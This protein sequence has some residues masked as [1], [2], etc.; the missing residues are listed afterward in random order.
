[1]M[2]RR[3]TLRLLLFAAATLCC[4]SWSAAYDSVLVMP[5]VDTTDPMVRRVVAA[6]R[7]TIQRWR[8]PPDAD[9]DPDRRGAPGNVAGI[10]RNWCSPTPAVV[11]HFPATIMSV[12]P[13][14]EMHYVARVIISSTDHAGSVIPFAIIRAAFDVRDS[15]PVARVPLDEAT[16]EWETARVGRITYVFPP[17]ITFRKRRAERANAFLLRTAEALGVQP[18]NGV[19][20]VITRDR[21]ELCSILGVEYLAVPPSAITYPVQRTV[22]VGTHEEAYLHELVHIVLADYPAGHEVIREGIAT[23]YGGSLGVDLAD[24][25]TT[26]ARKT[27]PLEVPTLTQL[28]TEGER[29]QDD[30]YIMGAV[31]CDAIRR[32]HGVNTLID[33]LHITSTALTLQRCAELLTM[34]PSDT[35]VTLTDLLDETVQAVS[36]EQPAR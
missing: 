24:L 30:V 36:S 28:F 34:E 16:A 26:Y 14:G 23:L 10:I 35:M 5:R 12:E 8:L 4:T 11:K 2:A 18:P 32:R 25:V 27:P 7:D 15:V 6:L 1:M 19:R 13:G 33:L 29:L 20:Y 3:R 9:E 17:D 22:I 21:D 31:V